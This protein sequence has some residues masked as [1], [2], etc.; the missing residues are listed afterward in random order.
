MKIQVGANDNQTITIDLKQIDAKTLGLDGFSVKNN[1][2]VTTSAPVTA[3]VLPP[4]TILNLLELPF[5]R[6]Q[7][8]ILAELTQLQLRVFILIMVMITMRKSP[9]V[10]TMGSITQ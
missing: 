6:K 7:P 8:L 2:T 4:Q 5:L 3:L 1:D 10:I 9:V